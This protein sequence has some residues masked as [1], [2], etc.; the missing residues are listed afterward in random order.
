MQIKVCY[1]DTLSFTNINII[2][3]IQSLL[4]NSQSLLHYYSYSY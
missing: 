4:K 3:N 1:I 2:G